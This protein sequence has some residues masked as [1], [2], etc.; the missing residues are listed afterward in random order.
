MRKTILT[1]ITATLALGTL[2][3][4][5]DFWEKPF[6]EWKR[7][8]VLK[9]LNDSPWAGEVVAAF[10][11]GGKDSGISGEKEIYIS[12]TIRFFSALPVRQAYVRMMQIINDYDKMDSGQRSQF[13][14]RFSRALN[15]DTSGQIIVAMEF[16]SNVR[17]L[18]MQIETFLKTTRSEF[19]KQ[20]AYLISDRLGRVQMLEYY[21]PS[22]DG[23]GAKFIF[24][25]QVKGQ[26]VISTDDK[27][28]KFEIVLPDLGDKVLFRKKVDKMVY[29]GQLEI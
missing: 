11:L 20:R 21:P 16:G 19:L 15:M 26:P 3:L 25:R 9:M 12:Y 5:K 17:Q 1:A 8:Q 7:D 22:P 4:A 14:Q 6:T 13:D 18:N 23:T 2:A 28:I 10:S 29:N 27:E 24:P